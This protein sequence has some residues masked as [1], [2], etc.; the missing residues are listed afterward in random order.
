MTIARGLF[1]NAL[2]Y[3]LAICWLAFPLSVLMRGPKAN[4]RV[5]GGLI[6]A[7]SVILLALGM[8]ALASTP[9][10]IALP[11]PFSLGDVPIAFTLDSLSG[12]FLCVIAI[13][14]GLISPYLRG[15][16]AHL[17]D[18][19]DMR[20]FWTAL[21]ALI[22]SMALVVLSANALTFLVAWEVMSLTSAILIATDHE[23][24][25]TRGATLIYLGATRIATAFLVGGFLWAH[26]LTGTWTFADWHI[27]GIAALGPGLLVLVGL[28]IKAGSWP[29]HL[30]LPI[31]HPAAPAPV[32][33]LM[34]GVMVKVAIAA[35]VRLFVIGP[36][37]DHPE[38]GIVILAAGA[39]SSVWGVLFAL[40]QH[41]LK[42]LL[43]YHT[44][45]NVGLILMG[46]G[47]CLVARHAGLSIVAQVALAAGLFHVLNHAVFKSLLFLGAGAVDAGAGTRN[48]DLLGGLGKRM[49]WTYACFAIGAAAICALPPLNGFA[50]EW[51]LYQSFLG[52]AVG[53]HSPIQ[54]FSFLLLIGVLALVGAL[55]MACFV[56]AIGVTFLGRPRSKAA[57]SA[58]EA[59]FGMLAGQGA[60]AALC[61][62]LGLAPPAVLAVL[63]P[64]TR[65]A[66]P[67]APPLT[68][69]WTLPTGAMLAALAVTAF[70]G[71]AWTSRARRQRPD[72]TYI[73]WECGFGALSPRQQVS[74]TS[75]VQPISRIFS[76]VFQYAEN[77]RIE[78][79]SRRLFPDRV[80]ATSTTEAVLETRL[81]GP[82]TMLFKWLGDQVIK[83]Q[84]G[85][86]HAYLLTMLLTLLIL[87]AIG[88][89]IR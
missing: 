10:T 32:S 55:A 33:A 85:N 76:V 14:A 60:L 31:A 46:I 74:A 57:E 89:S 87:L 15:Y 88:G 29:F 5:L 43:A 63:D 8:T 28:G 86:I 53:A 72:R 19:A 36:A 2:L 80:T 23:P 45:E 75:F 83:L 18:R 40:I 81:Y 6:G 39:V 82:L 52:G 48:L 54:R 49:K 70:A 34:S 7:G 44:V 13:I 66:I 27:S 16:C 47:T 11:F 12:F 21:P 73:T 65:A 26:A 56:K 24:K 1:E 37:F 77:L 35:M 38:L 3:S 78:G 62:F 30:W 42:R 61:V 50:S 67:G 20:I 41:D 79:E 25:A 84:E 22:L 51:L 59:D 69:A 71:A 17:A 64:V 9:A 4:D 68:A 58:R